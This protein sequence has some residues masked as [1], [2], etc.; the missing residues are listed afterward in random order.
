MEVEQ[1]EIHDT[2]QKRLQQPSPHLDKSLLHLAVF[3]CLLQMMSSRG[4]ETILRA[5]GVL[6]QVAR[7][8]VQP[9]GARGFSTRVDKSLLLLF[10]VLEGLGCLMR[11]SSS[12]FTEAQWNKTL[13]DFKKLKSEVAAVD[14]HVALLF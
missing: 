6:D 10:R 9:R 2:I 1:R 8:V 3:F 12:V 11:D 5:L 13:V 7:L 4:P 14:A